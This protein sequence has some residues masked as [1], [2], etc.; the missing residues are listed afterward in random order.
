MLTPDFGQQNI[1]Y[2]IYYLVGSTLQA[3]LI[4]VCGLVFGESCLIASGF[5]Y[6]NVDGKESYNNF[7][8]MHIVDFYL[9]TDLK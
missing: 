9:A 5:G 3:S 2:K 6:E 4:Y 7:Y 8:T 1:I